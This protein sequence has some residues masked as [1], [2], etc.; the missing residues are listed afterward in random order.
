[1]SRSQQVE[2]SIGS[3]CKSVTRKPVSG[4]EWGCDDSVLLLS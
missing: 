1:M 3:T 2:H 4:F